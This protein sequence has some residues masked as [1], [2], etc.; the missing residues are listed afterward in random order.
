M[1]RTL[2]SWCYHHRWTVVGVW[3]ALIVGLNAAGAAIGSSFNS[4]F[5]TPASESASGF[6]TLNEY[7]PGASSVFGGQIVF[8][9]QDG[10]TSEEIAE[11]MTELFDEVGAIEGVT[12]VSPYTPFG[13]EQI[14]D[15]GTIAFAQ[16][17]L[18]RDI[19][20]PNRP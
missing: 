19:V 13:A 10:V 8:Q 7:F 16:L 4:G 3:I 6:D 17:N 20:K 12:V 9:T 11:P 18:A 15:D 14:N 5:E 2:A 1:Y